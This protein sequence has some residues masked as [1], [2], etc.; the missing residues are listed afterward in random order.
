MKSG[1]S[2]PVRSFEPRRWE[3]SMSARVSLAQ[4]TPP[5]I[6]ALD[7]GSSS[8]RA[9]LF[10]SQGRTVTGLAARRKV[11]IMT[12]Q[13]GAAETDPDTLLQ[14]VWQ[15]IDVILA[16]VGDRA[17][18]IAGVASSIFVSNIMGVDERQRPVTPLMT[19]AD[20]RPS[21]DVP[22]LR[23]LADE[24]AAHQRTGCLFHPSYWPVR[25][26][27]MQRAK[28]DWLR[29]ATRWISLGDYMTL[30][31][32]GQG[33]ISHS[34]ASWTGLLNRHT[35]TWDEDLLR[36][37]PV[38][39]ADFSPLV[40][41]NQSQTELRPSFAR[42]WP[43][44]NGIPWFPAVGDGAAANVG[45]G[46]V[47]PSRLALTVGTTSAVRFAT[48]N[49][50]QRVP[51][52]LWCYR[53]DGRRAL[54]GG[55][56]TEGGNVRT[57]IQRNFHLDNNHELEQALGA[58]PPDGHGLT[59]LPLLMGERS[60]GWNA[61]LRGGILGL[62]LATTPI[63]VLRAGMEGVSYRV[64]EVF[65]RLR[66]ELATDVTVVASGG[67]LL[68]SPTWLQIM[69]DVLGVPVVASLVSEASARGVALLALVALG[70]LEDVA[71][72]PVYFGE[73][74]LPNFTAHQRYLQAMRRQQSLYNYMN[75][76]SSTPA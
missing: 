23:T 42:R 67:A 57:W 51:D 54:V 1:Q 13:D 32:F 6:L 28:P 27:W 39:S 4:A 68:N 74:Y 22:R 8:V 50:V 49:P 10:D 69:A 18:E 56:L 70:V 3:Q 52:G 45:S 36:V 71:D 25:F 65:R 21:Q 19:Y 9:L 46:C 62:S 48:Q 72:A 20:T 34:V 14:R 29:K 15:C 55:A 37:L 43:T 47:S 24:A 76:L 58:L 35:L 7:I 53:V 40:H 63:D 66:S 38:T 75:S 33:I 30:K 31:L 61:D 64:A 16:Q 12:G 2:L 44:L 73:S 59:F 5:L 26:L 11:T 41:V 60:P 17:K